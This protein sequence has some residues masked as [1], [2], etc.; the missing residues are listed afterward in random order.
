MLDEATA[1]VDVATDKLIQDAIKQ[2]FADLTVLTIAH[3]LNTIMESDKI[4]V[5]DAGHVVEFA[6]PLAL[7]ERKDGY[8]H[9]LLK[10]TGPDSF[11]KLTKIAQ[12]KTGTSSKDD[13]D[14]FLDPDNIVIDPKTNKDV[15]KKR[16][17]ELRE[18]DKEFLDV[19]VECKILRNFEPESAE[20]HLIVEVINEVESNKCVSKEKEVE[21]VEEVG[22]N[23]NENF[24]N[25]QNANQIEPET[26]E[27]NNE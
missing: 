16:I 9:N 21:L 26:I 17:D 14:P 13:C 23:N 27:L 3:R 6:P 8:F 11:A 22:E 1:A 10:E 15:V 7:L 20:Q 25:Q 19:K 18:E 2:N 12:N 4:L 5:M 24:E